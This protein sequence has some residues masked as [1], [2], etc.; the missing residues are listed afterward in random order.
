MKEIRGPSY[1]VEEQKREMTEYTRG[2]QKKRD[3]LKKYSKINSHSYRELEAYGERTA[4][5]YWKREPK[6]GKR[7]GNK[8]TPETVGQ[9]PR[10][11]LIACSGDQ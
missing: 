11:Y 7:T 8:T 10:D 9:C 5:D 4:M 1:D 6:R 3:S 2:V